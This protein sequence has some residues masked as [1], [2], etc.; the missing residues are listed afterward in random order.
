[1]QGVR[2]QAAVPS[3]APVREQSTLHL[4]HDWE[5]VL[6]RAEELA[7]AAELLLAVA[8][9]RALA[10]DAVLVELRDVARADAVAGAQHEDLGAA[11]ADVALAVDRVLLEAEVAAEARELAREAQA[12]AAHRVVDVVA[13]IRHVLKR[14]AA[15]RAEVVPAPALIRWGAAVAEVTVIDVLYI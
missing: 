14:Y 1:M 11:R 9:Q 5:A 2:R 3:A 7:V 13:R 12:A 8:A 4:L 6:D 15:R 10:A